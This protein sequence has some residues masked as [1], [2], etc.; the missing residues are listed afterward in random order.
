MNLYPPS[1]F[2][3]YNKVKLHFSHNIDAACEQ[4]NKACEGVGTDEKVLVKVLG[5]HSPNDRALIAYRYE[6]LYKTT[7]RD[8]VKSET[9]GDFN[10]LLQLICMSVPHAEAYVIYH[11]MKGVGTSEQLIYPIVLGRTNEEIGVLKKAFFDM[12]ETDL[13][14]M[15]NDDLSGEFHQIVT[16]ALQA[17]QVEYK[18]H[19][20][21]K[22]KAAEDAE[23]IYKAGEGKWGTDEGAF[24]KTILASPPKHL[25]HIEEIYKEKYK[26]GLVFAIE[27]EFSGS[28][29][30]ALS[31]HVNLS[32]D[33]WNTLADL[34]RSAVDGIGT[35]EYSLSAS[36][37]R[38]HPYMS[39]IKHAFEEKNKITLRERV[40]DETDGSFQEL[41][42]HV[43]DA[44]RSIGE[45]L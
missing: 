7:L 29:A 12:Y 31:F 30:T 20:H 35:D 9:S 44:P 36:L 40:H 32:L 19:F 26:H 33:P 38:Y 15:A 24:V 39:K 11:A 1:A 37:V 41:L 18:H 10:Y 8:L 14:V 34:I 45:Y 13:S 23:K 27:S 3:V 43:I 42:M 4:I 6:E 16:T 28:S 21:T 5:P 2:D 17:T 25:Q 22:E